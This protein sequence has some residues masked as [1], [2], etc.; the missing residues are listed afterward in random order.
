MTIPYG[1][2]CDSMLK[3][4]NGQM[5]GVVSPCGEGIEK[6]YLDVLFRMRLDQECQRLHKSLFFAL[7][8]VRMKALQ[9]WYRESA[10]SN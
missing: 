4:Q 5:E 9:S 7:K 6:Y 2:C 3:E 10:I 1:K 8:Q